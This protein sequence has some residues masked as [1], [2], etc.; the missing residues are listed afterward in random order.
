MV[1]VGRGS[2]AYRHHRR[3]EH[4][5][6]DFRLILR[7]AIAKARK[8]SGRPRAAVL[9]P[10][11]AGAVVVAAAPQVAGHA[12]GGA[13]AAPAARAAEGENGSSQQRPSGCRRSRPA[14]CCCCCCRRPE[15]NY[16]EQSVPTMHHGAGLVP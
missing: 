1:A 10:A 12:G 2:E 13:S 4:K 8:R 16:N 3:H 7:G 15:A 5:P 11:A 9:P 14:A 6:R